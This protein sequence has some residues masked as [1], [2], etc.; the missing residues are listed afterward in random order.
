MRHVSYE[1]SGYLLREAIAISKNDV[2]SVRLA[3]CITPGDAHAIDV[4]YHMKCWSRNVSNVLRKHRVADT[5]EVS[6]KSTASLVE[7]LACVKSFHRDGN[8]TSVADL[9][10]TYLNICHSNGVDTENDKVM[11]RREVKLFLEEEISYIVFSA[12]K[13]KNKSQRASL[14]CMV[15]IAMQEVEDEVDNLDVLHQAAIH[16]RKACHTVPKWK[17]TGSLEDDEFK[18]PEELKLFIKW[19]LCGS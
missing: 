6:P 17:F 10:N 8:I 19:F 16:L 1:S 18:I 14:K 11:S 13:R 15:D 12:P 3:E 2:L 4:Y 9:H 5:A 7:F